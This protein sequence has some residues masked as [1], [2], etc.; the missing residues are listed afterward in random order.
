MEMAATVLHLTIRRITGRES[1][2]PGRMS[3][4]YAALNAWRIPLWLG[5]VF[6]LTGFRGCITSFLAKCNTYYLTKE[7]GSA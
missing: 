2:T 1:F 7:M 4:D 5:C 6:T 3:Y